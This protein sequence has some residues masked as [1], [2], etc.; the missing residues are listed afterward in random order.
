MYS[1][2]RTMCSCE[3]HTGAQSS[4][5]GLGSRHRMPGRDAA[6]TGGLGL[7]TSRGLSPLA[8]ALRCRA[9]FSCGTAEPLLLHCAWKLRRRARPGQQPSSPEPPAAEL[10]LGKKPS[11]EEKSRVGLLLG[12]RTQ[13]DARGLTSLS[14]RRRERRGHGACAGAAGG[15]NAACRAVRAA[16]HGT[17]P[18]GV[19][20]R[21]P[22]APHV[23]GPSSARTA[24][25][26]R[27]RRGGVPVTCVLR[28]E[29]SSAAATVWTHARGRRA[30]G[31]DSSSAFDRC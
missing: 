10:M 2:H 5:L 7:G 14:A 26:R 3:L 28:C 15:S 6:Q 31:A 1:K 4:L 16:S 30:A 9:R 23:P 12:L 18:P 19:Q 21:R 11:E 13:A 29:S 20:A 22:A 24:A 25:V 8:R 17:Q 27:L